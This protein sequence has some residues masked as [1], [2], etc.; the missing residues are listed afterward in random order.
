M[1]MLHSIGF[2]LGLCE[3]YEKLARHIELKSLF[4]FFK[5]ECAMCADSRYFV[6]THTRAK[7]QQTQGL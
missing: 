3:V 6:I 2:A 1:E 5:V 4:V 7:T